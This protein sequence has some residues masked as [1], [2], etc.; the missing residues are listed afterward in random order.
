MLETQLY[1]WPSRNDDKKSLHLP[2][3]SDLQGEGLCDC[4]YSLTCKLEIS[5]KS[6]S[7]NVFDAG[8]VILLS[9]HEV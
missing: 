5:T 8:Y 9:V 6:S 2:L 4:S 7:M 1:S 3:P